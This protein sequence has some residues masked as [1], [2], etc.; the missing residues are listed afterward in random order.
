MAV[1]PTTTSKAVGSKVQALDWNTYV[2]GNDDFF[3]YNRPLCIAK[4]TV[5]QSLATGTFTPITMDTEVL[6]RD[7]QH[8]TVTNTDRVVIGNTLGWYRVSGTVAYNGGAV[9]TRIASVYLN[10]L[11]TQNTAYTRVVANASFTCVGVTAIVQ[12][13]AAG[14]YVQIVGWQDSGGA[15]S[16]T[17]ASGIFGS[18]T[19]E[20]IGS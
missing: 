6:D 10:G 3:I 16:T 7:N 12:A 20:W 13:T 19:V 1:L 8:S 17:V 11:L 2:K 5:S 14:D 15:L 9:G 4:Q 18:I